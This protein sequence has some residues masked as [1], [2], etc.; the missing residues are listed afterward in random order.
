MHLLFFYLC[1]VKHEDIMKK[2]KILSLFVCLVAFLSAC[3]ND[4][5]EKRG[6]QLRRFWFI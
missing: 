6:E 3:N 2:I 1:P 4:E 5:D